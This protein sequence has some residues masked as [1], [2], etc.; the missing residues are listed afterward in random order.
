[1]YLYNLFG[2]LKR[3]SIQDVNGGEVAKLKRENQINHSFDY[4]YLKDD[5]KN[6][7]PGGTMTVRLEA[8]KIPTLTA[9]YSLSDDL[10]SIMNDLSFAD[11]EIKTLE[12]TIHCHKFLLAAR[13]YIFK[14]GSF[15]FVT[16]KVD[17]ITKH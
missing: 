2:P 4:D 3:L 15:Y 9:A 14:E 12:G 11:C 16:I 13:S 17:L 5:L 10:E 7:L 1:M 8:I 6:L